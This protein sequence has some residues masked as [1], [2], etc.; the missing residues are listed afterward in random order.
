MV[1]LPL[2][3]FYGWVTRAKRDSRKPWVKMGGSLGKASW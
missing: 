1:E 2:L 3:C